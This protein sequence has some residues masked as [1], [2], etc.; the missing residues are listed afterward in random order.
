MASILGMYLSA[1]AKALR[2]RRNVSRDVSFIEL[3]IEEP[4]YNQ[5][6]QAIG[7]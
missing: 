3:M 1:T 5:S 6:V 4:F 7:K 2:L